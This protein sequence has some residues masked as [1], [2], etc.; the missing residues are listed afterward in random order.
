M[1]RVTQHN[2][3]P[4]L[5]FLAVKILEICLFQTV[6]TIGYVKL[7]QMVC[8][9]Q[10]FFRSLTIF[11]LAGQVT[12][13]AGSGVT[14]CVDGIGPNAAFSS[15]IYSIIDSNNQCLYVSDFDNHKIRK[16]TFEGILYCN[17]Y[18]HPHTHTIHIFIS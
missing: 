2:S 1:V 7:P 9:L 15:P 13:V 4:H 5:G 16:V 17:P 14:G 8:H 10:S 18:L 6:T 3:I 12:T 11:T